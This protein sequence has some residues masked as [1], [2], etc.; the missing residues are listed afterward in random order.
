MF[1]L[2]EKVHECQPAG[3][4]VAT[5]QETLGECLS[6][7]WVC[8]VIFHF[9]INT[10]KVS[11][12]VRRTVVIWLGIHDR[13]LKRVERDRMSLIWAVLRQLRIVRSMWVIL[14]PIGSIAVPHQ[15]IQVLKDIGLRTESLSTAWTTEFLES[16]SSVSCF[17][18]Q[19][20]WEDLE[21]QKGLGRAEVSSRLVSVWMCSVS[22]QSTQVPLSH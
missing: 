17:G 13:K 1:I 12:R 20:E 10:I 3:I 4:W 14:I 22:C 21:A 2:P 11:V 16:S 5:A 15:L 7:A 6:V 18:H 8:P 9:L 19:H